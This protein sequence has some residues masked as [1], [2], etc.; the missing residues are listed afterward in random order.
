MN[1]P[2]GPTALGGDGL[3]YVFDSFRY[4][5]RITGL[6]DDPPELALVPAPA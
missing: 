5:A 3:P 2:G 4:E 1:E 6:E